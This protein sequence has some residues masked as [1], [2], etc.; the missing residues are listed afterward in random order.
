MEN[1]ISAEEKRA[2]TEMIGEVKGIFLITKADFVRKN[3]GEEGVKK[4]EQAMADFGHPL[5]YKEIKPTTSYPLG[6]F[7]FHFT[8]LN[9][10]FGY[11]EKRFVE[12]GKAEARNSSLLIRVF[13]SHFVSLDRLAQAVSKIWGD[14]FSVGSLK[15]VK[16]N[17]EAKQFTVRLNDFIGDRYMCSSLVGYFSSILGMVVGENVSCEETKC[18]RRGDSYHEFLLKW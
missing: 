11:D 8:A 17:K 1:I 7:M 13:L 6:L 16:V 18:V 15:T 10:L 2:F 3:E 14:H 12:M 4:L 5:K 9:R